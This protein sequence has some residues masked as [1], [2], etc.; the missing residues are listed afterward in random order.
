MESVSW[1]NNMAPDPVPGSV[2]AQSDEED[3]PRTVNYRIAGN[4]HSVAHAI[5]A[6]IYLQANGYPV[7]F[8][9]LVAPREP[10][11]CMSVFGKQQAG[12]YRYQKLLVQA[13][14]MAGLFIVVSAIV[15]RVDG[16]LW[17]ATPL[18]LGIMGFTT[19]LG[20]SSILFHGK[21]LKELQFERLIN[22]YAKKKY[23]TLL[24]YADHEKLARHALR[25]IERTSC[26]NAF[27]CGAGPIK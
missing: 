9:E 4:Y 13:V 1:H 23:W 24:I 2:S 16:A 12:T 5:T 15:G 25:L 3:S 20:G 7:E 10:L 21:P 26:K 14:V 27:V 6:Q 11:A 18:T 22:R 17:G 8:I 19:A